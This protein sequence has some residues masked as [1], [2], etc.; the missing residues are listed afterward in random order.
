[1]RKTIGLL[2][3]FGWR[4]QHYIASMKGVI[5]NINPEA[6]IIDVSH[7]ISSY[8]IIETQYILTSTRKYFPG[9]TVFIIV[10]DPGVGSNREI[11]ALKTV[12]NKFFVGPNNGIF[13]SIINSEIAECVK[14]ENNKYFL[15]P[16][17]HTF[18][19]RDIMAPVGA[20]ISRGIPLNEMGPPFNL[21]E[22]VRITL[23]LDIN[24]KNK[25]ISCT[26]QYIDAFGN[27]TTNVRLTEDN[28]VASSTLYFQK[29]SLVTLIQENQ[30]ITKGNFST[31]YDKLGKGE[32]LFMR[33]STNYLEIS[34]NQADAARDLNI[35]IGD[36]IKVVL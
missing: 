34:K 18:H 23:I 21:D 22:I 2:T 14:V 25:E 29:D 6:T 8:S 28:H 32:L 3:D 9:G 17:S 4:G 36:V 27:I 15:H 12:D 1:M 19:G 13:S 11:L 35:K 20:Q 5:L 30:K 16:V 7:S 33:G 31:H 10:I 26:V 24:E